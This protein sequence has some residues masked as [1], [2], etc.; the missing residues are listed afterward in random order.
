MANEQ[1]LTAQQRAMLFAAAT[2]QHIQ[3]I[4]PKEINS[5][6]Q[7]MTFRLPQARLTQGVKLFVEGTVNLTA[8]GS[9]EAGKHDALRLLTRVACDFNNGFR[10]IQGSGESLALV[11]MLYPNSGM[12]YGATAGTLVRQPDSW[13]NGENKFS[14]TL[15]LPFTTNFRDFSGIILTQN[16]DTNL[17]CIVDIGNPLK[18]FSQNT[19]GKITGA[20]LTQLKITPMVVSYSVP[21]D[22][23]AMPDMS[24]LKVVSE[25]SYNFNEGMNYIKVQTGMI[26]RKMLMIFEKEDGTR[27]TPEEFESNI[28]L[29]FNTAD[30]PYIMPPK[31]FRDFNTWQAG[32]EMPEG[33]YFWSFDFAGVLGYGGSRDLVDAERLSELGIRFHSKVPGKLIFVAEKLSRLVVQG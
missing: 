16:A 5:G 9:V 20:D 2:R 29:V 7:T 8:S 21:S 27:M 22:A 1:K 13:V 32:V 15:D 4:A 10:P 18:M 31:M 30:T 33:V 11:S 19:A 3:P 12:M 17:D 6:F 14:F 28:E 23:R 24:I 25:N 26:Y